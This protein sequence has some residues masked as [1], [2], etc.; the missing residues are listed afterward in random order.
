MREI[1][2]GI[3]KFFKWVLFIISFATTFYIVLSMYDRL[4]KNII[5]SVDIFI[6]FIILLILFFINLVAKQN[7]V[8]KNL[9]YNLTS[10][11]VFL[12][13]LIVD[14]RTI[15]DKNMVLSEIMGY[16]INFSY[17]S[18]FLSFMKVLLYGLSI[19]N[20]F[21]MFQVK[22]EKKINTNQISRKITASPINDSSVEVL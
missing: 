3:L 19:A 14:V 13:I 22:K 10:V 12:T 9:F 21:F 1:L 11:I 16:G 7:S 18:D 4:D 8:S 17:F 15:F 6:P 2:N 20:I 5:E